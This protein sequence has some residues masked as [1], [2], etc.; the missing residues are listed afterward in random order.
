MTI[1][2]EATCESASGLV[3]ASDTMITN[4]FLSINFEHQGRKMNALSGS[5]IA[6]TAGDALAYTELFNQVELE[7]SRLKDCS[8][9]EIVEAIKKCYQL[10]RRQEISETIL[11]PR[12]FEDLTEFHKAQH[13]LHPEIVLAIQHEIDRY[14][15]GLQILV[16]G[17][18]GRSAHIYG[19][20]DPGTSKCFDS[21]NFTAIGSGLPHAVNALIAREYHE[22]FSMPESLMAV[23]EAKSRSEKAPG[24][25]KTTDI[26]V[27]LPDQRIDLPR[28][29]IADLGEAY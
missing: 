1:C 29:A 17:L 11:V 24:V 10:I 4:E 22:G 9:M 26:T 16:A 15:Y 5:C 3:L 23:Y 27:L 8:V 18:S 20:F 21:I 25:G 6:L 13:H 12:G 2:I 28:K 7:I 14:D 19:V